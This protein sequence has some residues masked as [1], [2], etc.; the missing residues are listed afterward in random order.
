MK[1]FLVFAQLLGAVAHVHAAGVVLVYDNEQAVL[2][3]T[4][5][6]GAMVGG[7][8]V[9]PADRVS[10]SKSAILAAP[11][12]TP[13]RTTTL[14]RL[15]VQLN[16][17]FL[18]FGDVVTSSLVQDAH[19]KRSAAFQA[20]LPDASKEG[21]VALAGSAPAFEYS[22]AQGPFELKIDG[23]LVGSEAIVLKKRLKK[24]KFK[25]DIVSVSTATIWNIDVELT[26]QPKLSFWKQ[27]RKSSLNDVPQNKFQYSQQIMF[28]PLAQ[29][30]SIQ[31]PI[32]VFFVEEEDYVWTFKISSKHLTMERKALIKFKS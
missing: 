13:L 7:G 16:T 30:K 32:E 19:T 1:K 10:T 2:G 27:G 23:Q 6:L 4:S 20:F 8:L 21:A 18:K 26:S 14:I 28:K 3:G 12:G 25:L 31:I 17:A 29:G 9:V 15:D 11:V 5:Y 22:S 24:S